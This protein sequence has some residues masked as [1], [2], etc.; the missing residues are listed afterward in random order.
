M[1]VLHL[2]KTSVGATWAF[3]QMREL[4]K[5]GVEVHVAVPAG[6]L[7]VRQYQEAGVI[8]HL[9]T[10]DFPVQ[11]PQRWQSIIEDMRSLVVRVQP[12][13]IHSHSVGTTLTM[14]LALGKADST[15]RIFQVPGP[16]HLEHFFFR[17]VELVIAGRSDY[18]IGSCQWT[19]KR[20]RQSGVPSDR[21]F[22][23]YYGTDLDNF[24]GCEPG[25]LRKVLGVDVDTKLVGMVAFM[26]APKRYLGQIRG[27]KGHEDLID[28]LALC[29]EAN[30]SI[31]GV[32]IGGAWNN[33]VSYENQVRAYGKAH[34]GN[35][36]VFLGTRS[37]VPELYPD[38]DVVVH[39]S[40]SEN[41]GGAA[42]SL[43]LA[44]PTIATNVGGLPDLVE[45]GETGW[46]VPARNPA[47]LA[48]CILEA[49][50]E[51]ERAHQMAVRGQ[52]LARKLFDVRETA[53]QVLGVYKNIY[54]RHRLG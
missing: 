27:I 39:P 14:R 22:L 11:L 15:P 5:L 2:V 18:W 13:I 21:I 36:T 53:H 44:V 29:L 47:Q 17:W 19:C 51:P 35:R 25:K 41:V 49:V 43:L 40:H 50:S 7:L 8:V 6:G 24:V 32:F 16:L 1:R 34:C 30:S 20:Y 3:R 46:L 10:L 54:A 28:A 9:V 31:L 48:E 33:A 23:S 4:V 26:Y 45:P 52:A 42:E 37:D 38:L 12:D